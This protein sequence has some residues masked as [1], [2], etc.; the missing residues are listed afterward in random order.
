MNVAH[1]ILIIVIMAV[2]YWM[3]IET[4]VNPGVNVVLMIPKTVYSMKAVESK[5]AIGGK[6]VQLNIVHYNEAVHITMK[7]DASVKYIITIDNCK[8]DFDDSDLVMLNAGTPNV[9][10]KIVEHRVYSINIPDLDTKNMFVSKVKP[11]GS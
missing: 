7:S 3:T 11:C 6:D 4:F 2:V 10:I 8:G 9:A 5:F 1:Y